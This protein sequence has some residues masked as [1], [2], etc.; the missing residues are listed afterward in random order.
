MAPSRYRE[1]FTRMVGILAPRTVATAGT[2][3]ARG[4]LSFDRMAGRNEIN[5]STE[6]TLK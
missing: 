2:L 1:G 3:P 5:D 4:T 6:S